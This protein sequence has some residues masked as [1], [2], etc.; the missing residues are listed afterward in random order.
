MKSKIL[1]SVLLAIAMLIPGGLFLSANA[2]QTVREAPTSQA[3]GL[4]NSASA[5]TLGDL[6]TGEELSALPTTLKTKILAQ[7]CQALSGLV[8]P[9]IDHG[10]AARGAANGAHGRPGGAGGLGCVQ[11]FPSDTTMGRLQEAGEI[12]IGVR[13]GAPQFGFLNPVTGEVEGFDVD[14]GKAIANALGVTPRFI[15]TGSPDRIPFLTAGTVDLVIATMT[16]TSRRDEV[17]DF[18]EPYYVAHNRVLVK[19]DSGID[20]A[21]DLAGKTVCVSKGSLPERTMMAKVPE[22]NLRSLEEGS[23]VSCL[24]LLQSGEVD[25]IA[26]DDVLLLGILL[27]D[28]STSL[29]LDQLSVEPYGVGLKEGDTE[30]KK[31][32]DEVIADYKE[33]GAWK[34]SYQRWVGK[35]TGEEQEPPTITLQEALEIE[36]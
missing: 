27:Q 10:L 16:I 12:E 21:D 11:E 25:G 31:F 28:P 26:S 18:S 23:T 17:I 24:E 5:D 34:R 36:R 8:P 13:F 1:A 14:L 6:E 2:D 15:E 4:Q 19:K 30:F 35:Y 32:V 7:V 33:S 22:A 20:S 9:C 3:C 29:V